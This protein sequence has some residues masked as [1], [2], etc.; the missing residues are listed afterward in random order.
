MLSREEKQR[1]LSGP[2]CNTPK[3]VIE[4]RRKDS[5]RLQNSV[6]DRH[7]DWLVIGEQVG[8]CKACRLFVDMAK[9]PKVIGKF[10]KKS[11]TTYSRSKDLDEH[12]SN[13]YHKDAMSIMGL[14]LSI[15][16]SKQLPVKVKPDPELRKR[17]RN[18]VVR[19]LVFCARAGIALRG[20][21]GEGEPLKA[22]N[23]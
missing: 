12:T 10:R 11:W 13:Y 20:R 8:L 18:S 1:V 4:H 15:S 7:K 23:L 16:S 14:F 9:L 5:V 22:H 2:T 19:S 17:R 21:R 3:P 6:I